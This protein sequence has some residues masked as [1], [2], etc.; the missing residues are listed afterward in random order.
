MMIY[1]SSFPKDSYV[2]LSL[3][4]VLS[5]LILYI[6]V[7]IHTYIGTDRQTLPHTAIFL[8]PEM[9]RVLWGKKKHFLEGTGSNLLFEHYSICARRNDNNNS[10]KNVSA[11]F[12]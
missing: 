5:Y 10:N 12:P 4:K 7:C 1:V 6:Y 2:D 8:S 3:L 11:V 9:S